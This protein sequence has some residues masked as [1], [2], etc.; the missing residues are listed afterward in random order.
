MSMSIRL[1]TILQTDLVGSTRLATAVGPNRADALRDEHFRILR[2]AI[3]SSN[4][5]EV[6]TTGDGLVVAFP[7]ASAAVQCA[8]AMQQFLERSNR[9]SDQPRHIRIGLGAGESTIRDGDYFGIPSIEAA[10]LCD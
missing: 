9:H 4:G 2:E 5:H 1:A 8:V 6:K 3:A 7:S 10:R